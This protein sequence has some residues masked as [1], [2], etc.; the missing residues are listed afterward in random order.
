MLSGWNTMRILALMAKPAVPAG[1]YQQQM[2]QV[3]RA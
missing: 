3:L 2:G 1:V